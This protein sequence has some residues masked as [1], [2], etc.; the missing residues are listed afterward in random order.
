MNIQTLISHCFPPIEQVYTA[1][2]S[3]LYALS[4]GYGQDPMDERQLQ[5]VY[6][7]RPKTT[8]SMSL[9]MANP[10]FWQQQAWTGIDWVR[11]VLGEQRL[12]LHK[13]LPSSGRLIGQLRVTHVEDR[14]KSFGA[15]LHSERT[16]HD[17]ET[18]DLYSTLSMMSICR[19]DGGFGGT[20][21]VSMSLP[22]PPEQLP[23]ARCEMP[24][25]PQQA[26]LFDLHGIVNPIHSVPDAAREAGYPRPILHGICTLG[27]VH[28]ALTRELAG[29]DADRVIGMAARFRNPVYPGETLVTSMWVMNETEVIYQTH[30]KERGVLALH[31]TA[32]LSSGM[33]KEYLG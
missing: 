13:P 14:G 17:A 31:G 21:D 5:Y 28:H 9:V 22:V 18:G 23:D 16:L 8:G 30:V 10:G 6:G 20:S 15:L 29:Y 25:L 3:S 4:A 1:R 27:L 26:L 33:P 19:G 7:D 11:C 12:T 32:T 2:E 24:T